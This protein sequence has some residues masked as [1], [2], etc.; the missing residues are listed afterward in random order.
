ME[1]LFQFSAKLNNTNDPLSATICEVRPKN[2]DKQ[3]KQKCSRFRFRLEQEVEVGVV[4][5]SNL[6]QIS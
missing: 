5:L 3:L 6:V 2:T 4:T 1:T